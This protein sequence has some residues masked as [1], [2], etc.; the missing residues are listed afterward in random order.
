[1]TARVSSSWHFCFKPHQRSIKLPAVSK[2]SNKIKEELFKSLL[3]SPLN[4]QCSHFRMVSQFSE[5][6]QA[7]SSQVH[8]RDRCNL[9]KDM[10]TILPTDSNSVPSPRGGREPLWTWVQAQVWMK[11]RSEALPRQMRDTMPYHTSLSLSIAHARMHMHVHTHTELGR[12]QPKQASDTLV[13]LII[14]P[15]PHSTLFLAKGCKGTKFGV[16]PRIVLVSSQTMNGKLWSNNIQHKAIIFVIQ[17]I[18][19]I[20]G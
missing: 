19:L 18:L 20:D 12:F 14:I 2:Y 15:L 11:F 4:V 16:E 3:L 7:L 1:M 10:S 9:G 5:R 17:M 8:H 13:H 6:I